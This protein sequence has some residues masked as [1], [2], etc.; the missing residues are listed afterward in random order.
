M[1]LSQ[2]ITGSDKRALNVLERVGRECVCVCC[3]C[4]R[5]REGESR[6]RQYCTKYN[7]VLKVQYE[8]VEK[9]KSQQ[10]D[11]PCARKREEIKQL[12]IEAHARS[13]G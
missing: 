8:H 6:S 10:Q 3:V 2:I 11:A 4:E 1:T 7:I 5:E 9:E 12:Y 13:R